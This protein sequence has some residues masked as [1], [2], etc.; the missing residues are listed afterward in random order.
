MDL[1]PVFFAI[2]LGYRLP[3]LIEHPTPID[4]VEVSRVH[5]DLAPAEVQGIVGAGCKDRFQRLVLDKL[6]VAGMP[7]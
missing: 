2:K 6:A 3:H 7:L 1:T 4:G 5:G